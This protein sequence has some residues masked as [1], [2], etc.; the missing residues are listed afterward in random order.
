MN[1]LK[2]FFWIGC[3]AVVAAGCASSPSR[4]YSLNATALRTAA[5]NANY[6]VIV[7]PVTV[8]AAVERPQFVVTPAP[9]RVEVEE[10]NRWA[11]PLGDSIA[12]VVSLNLGEQL[13]TLRVAAAPMADFGPAYRVTIQLERFESVLGDGKQEGAATIDALWA[14]RGLKGESLVTGRFTLTEPAPGKNFELLAAA[15]SRLLEK[16]SASIAAAINHVIG[17]KP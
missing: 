5:P 13:G 2:S 3:V 10:F 9:N 7:G 15:H 16:L 4:F 14:V 8:P 17:E 1:Y 11:A 6:G 12:R